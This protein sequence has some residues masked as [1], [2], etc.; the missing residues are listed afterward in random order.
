MIKASRLLGAALV[1]VLA[2][3]AMYASPAFAIPKFK[4]PITNK[5][6]GSTSGTSVL[7]TPSES[8]VVTCG[9][10]LSA[11][12]IL[13]D[14]EASTTITFSSCSLKEGT[15]GPCTIKSVGA[16]GATI[17][18]ELLRLLLGLLHSPNGGAGV[19]LEPTSGHVFT[20]FAPT[21]SPCKTATTAVEGS[22][23]GLY[24]P[25]GKL[26]TTALINLGPTSA[27]GKQFVT[28][29]LTLAGIIKPKLTSF[30]AAE[31]TEEITNSVCFEEAVEV[32]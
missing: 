18:T 14:D 9:S 17:E 8:D 16:S 12:L 1:A 19:L 13:G 30:G 3:S 22:V 10:S 31:S 4:L 27:S 28:L 6:L 5:G 15:N 25:T 26:Q 32:D 2:A 11:G 29:I 20:T 24:S 7:R 23:A 21:S